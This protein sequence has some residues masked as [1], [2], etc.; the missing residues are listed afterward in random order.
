MQTATPDPRDRLLCV[1]GGDEGAKRKRRRGLKTFGT[2]SSQVQ[3]V[4]LTHPDLPGMKP[5][6]PIKVW[7]S[8]EHLQV[9]FFRQVSFSIRR[10]WAQAW[11]L[12]ASGSA[13]RA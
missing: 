1:A 10:T 2:F 5:V 12:V 3:G 7:G 9:N 4:D 13:Q 6:F 8:A 11:L